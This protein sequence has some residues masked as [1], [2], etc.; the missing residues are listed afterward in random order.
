M[1]YMARKKNVSGGGGSSATPPKQTRNGKP[2]HVWLDPALRE[3]IDALAED[4]RRSL[5]TEVA[6]ALEEHLRKA[7]RWPLPEGK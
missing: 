7:G 1:L 5:T 3:A 6:M 2:L 4:T